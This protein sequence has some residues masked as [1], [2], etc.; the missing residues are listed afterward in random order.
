MP[1]VGAIGSLTTPHTQPLTAM[2]LSGQVG[3]ARINEGSNPFSI[4]QSQPVSF[5]GPLQQTERSNNLYNREKTYG[6]GPD[7]PDQ[8][9]TICKNRNTITN[10]VCI[11]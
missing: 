3:A 10:T 8:Y 6:L 2:S 4:G 5:A 11:A 9:R 7:S 1:K